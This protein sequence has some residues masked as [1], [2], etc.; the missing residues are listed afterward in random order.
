LS[1]QAIDQRFGMFWSCCTD[2][3]WPSTFAGIA[4]QRELADN[5]HLGR[6]SGRRSIRQRT[7]HHTVSVVEDPKAPELGGKTVS[8]IRRVVMSHPD[9]DTQT[10]PNRPCQLKRVIS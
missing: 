4:V 1:D 5:E 2:P 7:V 9:E 6:L 10:R 8:V 3:T